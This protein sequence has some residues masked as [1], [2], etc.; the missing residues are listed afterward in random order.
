M[1]KYL[2]L[3]IFIVLF[4]SGCINQNNLNKSELEQYK[5]IEKVNLE[6]NKYKK[7]DDIDNYGYI[8]YFA[9]PNE[10]YSK[11]GGDCEDFMI[12]K[13]YKLLEN[14]FK[15]ENFQY[16]LVKFD[17][18][19]HF[20][21]GVKLN[22]TYYYLDNRYNQIFTKNDFRLKK[23]KIIDEYQWEIVSKYIEKNKSPKKNLK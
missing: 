9:S 4:C 18:E 15:E 16:L 8:D 13:K 6:I 20:I 3:N 12:T 1:I 10:F 14:G 2:I 17:E 22:N 21:L 7:I 5:V 19:Y 11:G 23:Y